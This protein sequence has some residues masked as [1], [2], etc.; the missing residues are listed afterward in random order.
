MEATIKVSSLNEIFEGI[1][2]GFIAKIIRALKVSDVF[3]GLY[4]NNFQQLQLV[5]R[6]FL[7]SS[8][9]MNSLIASEIHS[10]LLLLGGPE[11]AKVVKNEAYFNFL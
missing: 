8:V 7:H 6:A 5:E 9:C 11:K 10:K 3:Y 2:P 1:K 4:F